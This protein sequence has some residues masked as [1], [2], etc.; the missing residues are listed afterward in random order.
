MD[1]SLGS[2]ELRDG[3]LSFG[4]LIGMTG[5]P[6]TPSGGHATVDD[7]LQSALLPPFGRV[8]EIGCATGFTCLE[9]GAIRSD[10]SVE[11]VDV[12]PDAVAAAIEG[13]AAAGLRNVRF[14]VADAR[15]LPFPDA[16][17]DMVSC[18]NVPAF[19]DDR[20]AMIQECVRVTRPHGA[21]LA[22]P[23][24]Y[25]QPP[26]EEV[27]T[28]VEQAIGASIPV[29]DE[30]YW[31][32]LYE[33]HGLVCRSARRRRFRHRSR[34]DIEG[35]A[36]MVMSAPRNQAYPEK[37]RRELHQA[38][39]QS[40]DLF[41]ENNRYTGFSLLLFRKVAVNKSPILFMPADD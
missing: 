29:W 8:L 19:V 23:I 10:L 40:Y 1:T 21:V 39:V 27:R 17:F 30:H 3:G 2:P 20:S 25:V 31:L 32:S 35:Y 38:L 33:R 4:E 26:P 28:R 24:Y 16:T 13:A 22:V 6:N 7:V 5:E 15:S 14:S 34:D 37:T 9:M 36:R 18:G 41:N 11:G 12:N